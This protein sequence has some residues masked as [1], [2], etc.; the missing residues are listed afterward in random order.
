[1][2]LYDLFSKRRRFL[3]L[4]ERAWQAIES[5]LAIKA[6]A[7]DAIPHRLSC[8]FYASVVYSLVYQSAV[9]AGMN[10]SSAYSVTRIQLA[11]YPF[12]AELRHAVDA[13]F[14]ADEG[15]RER[16]FADHLQ[17][18]VGRIVA[19]VQ[20]GGVDDIDVGAELADLERFFA[21]QRFGDEGVT[22]AWL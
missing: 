18:T 15:S 1:M 20:A 22:P 17:Q 6:G 12:D 19:A 10:T 7:E 9:A 4:Y 16:R 2:T 5:H 13:I 11:K 8:F 3:P 14:P 21:E